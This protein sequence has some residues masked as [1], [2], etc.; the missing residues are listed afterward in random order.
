MST[1]NVDLGLNFT[2]KPKLVYTCA[3][4]CMI[5]FVYFTLKVKNFRVS[6]FSVRTFSA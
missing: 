2:P 6:T 4:S 3:C 5:A 1:L